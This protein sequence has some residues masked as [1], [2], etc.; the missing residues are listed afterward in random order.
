MNN[1]KYLGVCVLI[2][3]IIIAAALVVH[4]FTGRYQFQSSTPPG[5]IWVI[6]TWTGVVKAHNG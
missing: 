2:S 1:Q 4:T 6:D 3:S 5:V